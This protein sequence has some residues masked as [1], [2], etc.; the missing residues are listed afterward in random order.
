MKFE[1]R[2][3]GNA[4]ETRMKR[5]G[6]S[7]SLFGHPMSRRASLLLTLVAVLALPLPAARAA[8]PLL[9]GYAGPGSGEQVVL[10]GATVGGGGGGTSGGAGTTADQSLRA[11][12]SSSTSTASATETS[13]GASEHKSSS[14]PKAGGTS[15]TSGAATATATATPRPGA[16]RVVPYPTRAGA[17][18]GLPLSAGAVL[19]GVAGL[20]LL[21]LVGLGMRRLSSGPEEP[22]TAPQVSVR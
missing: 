16:P 7:A 1:D 21:V 17:S 18:S 14:K 22:P 11:T 15:S 8:D 3:A 9:S 5:L 6:T 4:H 2:M 20:A 12:T 10:G 19:L 13:T